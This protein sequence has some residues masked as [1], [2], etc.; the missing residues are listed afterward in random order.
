MADNRK[1]LNDVEKENRS[2][3]KEIKD[4]K[5]SVKFLNDARVIYDCIVSGL[6][7]GGNATAVDS[8]LELANSVGVNM[9]PENINDAHFLHKK[10][11]SDKK[12]SFVKFSNKQSKHNLMSVKPKLKE[13]KDS[14]CLCE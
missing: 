13:N 12:N 2:L 1:R 10:D 14:S 6:K 9:G 4:L 11:T 5:S 8:M 7:V 3:K